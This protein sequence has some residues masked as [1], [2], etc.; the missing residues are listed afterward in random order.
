MSVGAHPIK[1]VDPVEVGRNATFQISEECGGG[2]GGGYETNVRLSIWRLRDKRHGVVR[3]ILKPGQ[4]FPACGHLYRLAGIVPNGGVVIDRAPLDPPKGISLQAG[5]LT[6]PLGGSGELGNA[7]LKVD[8]IN[9][10]DAHGTLAIREAEFAKGPDEPPTKVDKR[11]ERVTAGGLV[12][13][14][15][16]AYRVRAIVAPDEKNDLP[17]WIEIDTSAVSSTGAPGDKR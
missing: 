8:A 17:G 2:N 7:E 15:G 11:T 12:Q 4:V 9:E 14:G 16:R 6:I 5:G 13:V 3:M 10:R 1:I